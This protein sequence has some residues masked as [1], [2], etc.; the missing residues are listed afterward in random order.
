MSEHEYSD[1]VAEA[2]SIRASE[3]VEKFSH[4]RPDGTG[5]TQLYK[6]LGINRDVCVGPAE[7]LAQ[8]HSY[9]TPQR[10]FEAWKNSSG[11]NKAMLSEYQNTMAIGS[12]ADGNT[13]YVVMSTVCIK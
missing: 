13:V 5:D 2:A 7:N 6:E 12:C 4:V 1:E 9:D 8:C 10:V 11:H 3:C